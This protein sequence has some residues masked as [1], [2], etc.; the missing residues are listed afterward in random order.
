M[1]DQPRQRMPWF[2]PA[3]LLAGLVLG[4]VILAWAGARGTE[5]NWH[6]DFHRFHPYISL[7]SQYQPT[8]GEMRA[9]V[10]SQCRPDQILVVVGGNSVFQGVGQPVARLWS[11][12]LQTELGHRYAVVNLAFRGSSPTDAG[13]LVAESLRA[14]Y[15]RQIYLANVPPFV[16]ASPG[17]SLDYR[18]MVLDAYYKGWLIKHPPRDDAIADYLDRTDV[19]PH[20]RELALGARL[21]A[22]LR[23]RD[24]WNRWSTER[25]FTFPTELTAEV[26]QAFRPRGKFKDDEPDFETMPFEQRFSP[27]FLETEMNI[28]RNTTAQFY[29]PDPAGGWMPSELEHRQFRRIASA[30]FPPELQART[31]I[32]LSRNSPYYTKRLSQAEQARDEIAFRDCVKIW[33]EIGYAAMAY[34][35]DFREADFGDRTH[36]TATGGEKLAL[37]VAGEVRTLAIRLGY[38]QEE[39]RR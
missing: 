21:D 24:F 3:T 27:R 2:N 29:E 15:P 25:F 37:Q 35:A 34:G 36:L 17:G 30:A 7:E 32:V 8:V 10:R 1:N 11:R 23:F 14:E 9:I 5:H 6:R 28:T 31:L 13:A 18:Y 20:A 19:Y 33:R 39:S 38:A 26:S 12:R 22:W 4:L 16:A